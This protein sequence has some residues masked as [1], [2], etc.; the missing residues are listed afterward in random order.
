M[1][2]ASSL[3]DEGH[4]H[5][6]AALLATMAAD[7]QA[8]SAAISEISSAVGAMDRAT[9]QNAAMVEE[10]SAA[11][12]SLNSEVQALSQ[13]AASFDVGEEAGVHDKAAV[14]TGEDWTRGDALKRARPLPAAAVAAL[15]RRDETWTSF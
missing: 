7:N 14:R 10:T 4:A 5:P 13:Q 11:A 1:G 9:Q 6:Q 15:V 3:I 12:R 2:R 8:Q